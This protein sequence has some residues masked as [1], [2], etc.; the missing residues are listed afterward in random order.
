MGNWNVN[1]GSIGIDWVDF[2]GGPG[3][4]T[5][6]AVAADIDFPSV[7]IYVDSGGIIG[8]S[9][10]SGST[11]VGANFMVLCRT[12]ADSS[13][14]QNKISV[15]NKSIRHQ[16]STGAWGVDDEVSWYVPV[17][18]WLVSASAEGAGFA[19]IVPMVLVKTTISNSASMQIDFRSEETNSGEGLVA[20]GASLI[21]RDVQIGIRVFFKAS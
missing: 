1:T 4:V 15:G 20:T 5:I 11:I 2:W 19:A 7:G 3:T 12:V 10:P 8:P 18:S 6:P 14:A 16:V 17:N 9:I 13:G 21:L